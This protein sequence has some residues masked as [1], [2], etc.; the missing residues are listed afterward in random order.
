MDTEV[1]DGRERRE[2]LSLRESRL[3][4]TSDNVLSRVM[5]RV[6]AQGG[7][8]VP[9]PQEAPIVLA[10]V[11]DE[12]TEKPAPRLLSKRLLDFPLRHVVTDVDQLDQEDVGHACCDDHRVPHAGKGQSRA[13]RGERASQG[14]WFSHIQK[15]V[16]I[17]HFTHIVLITK[18]FGTFP[19]RTGRYFSILG[20]PI[21][22][23]YILKLL[24]PLFLVCYTRT[25]MTV[26][27]ILYPPHNQHST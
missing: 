15:A 6:S 18:A 5:E 14:C 13:G 23:T 7:E 22:S 8:L 2:A 17:L 26:F 4:G 12:P 24:V 3:E 25:A 1:Y 10:C 21:T 11:H 19:I 16:T 20:T 27:C 9:V